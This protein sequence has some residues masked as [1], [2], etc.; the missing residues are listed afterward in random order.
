[1]K[2]ALLFFPGLL[3]GVGLAVSGMSNPAKVIG[4]LDVAGGNWDPSLA[5]VMVGAIGCF[6]LLNLLIHRREAPLFGGK[7][8]GPRSTGK[9]SPRVLVGAALFGVGWGLS[10]VCPGPAITDVSTLRGEVFAYLSAMLVGMLVAQRA[11]GAD[12]PKPAGG[13]APAQGGGG[14]APQPSS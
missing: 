6:G 3:F 4:F 7:L 10:G 9:P 11:F 13:D 2:H 12:A 8:P 14:A 5:L 1:M